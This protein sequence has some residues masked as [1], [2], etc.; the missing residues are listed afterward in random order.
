MSIPLPKISSANMWVNCHGSHK[1][2]EQFTSPK[3]SNEAAMRGQ[4]EHSDAE[5]YIL[6]GVVPT[7]NQ[8]IAS[9]VSDVLE[10]SKEANET[11]VEKKLPIR[12]D[13]GE[14]HAVPDT[15]SIFHNSRTV[16]IWEYKSGYLPVLSLDNWQMY[17]Y[18]VA[19][20]ERY[21][22]TSSYTFEFRVVQPRIRN[23]PE[24]S[25][26]K[27]SFEWKKTI[28]NSVAAALGNSPLCSSGP[29]CHYCSALSHCHTSNVAGKI[30]V[31]YSDYAIV[32][33]REL[34]LLVSDYEQLKA[35]EKFIR[36]L[37]DAVEI[38]LEN[39]L[40][41]GKNVVGYE[42]GPG[43]EKVEWEMPIEDVIRLGELY[44]V[45]IGKPGAITPKQ[46][47]K[48]G[49]PE[50]IVMAYAKITKTKEVLKKTKDDEY[51]KML[52]EVQ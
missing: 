31:S 5:V 47:I 51:V 34:S 13:N 50:V 21:P 17:G 22:V 26:L 18:A 3:E 30:A 2:S 9:Y 1:L 27:Y 45:N 32:D 35:A 40:R 10:I 28:N 39:E 15:F 4:K 52:K 20:V 36:K 37:A 42:L 14:L 19:I 44:K 46:A 8:Y 11:H 43:R 12:T 23:T 33:E 16:V 48:A 25:R 24:V 38:R 41:A 7:D 29:W 6:S 49:I